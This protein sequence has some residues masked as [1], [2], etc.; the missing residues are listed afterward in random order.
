[1]TTDATSTVEPMEPLM[2]VAR[3]LLLIHAAM[4]DGEWGCCHNRTRIQ[5]YMDGDHDALPEHCSA[6]DDVDE[7][8]ERFASLGP[9]PC[10]CPP[11]TTHDEHIEA[12]HNTDTP[13]GL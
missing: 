7:W 8:L 4:H 5:A 2:V 9:H 1:M 10:G 13:G 11:G 3:D 12:H 6:R